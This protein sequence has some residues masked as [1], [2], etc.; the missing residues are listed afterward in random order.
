MEYNLWKSV[1][2]DWVS[3]NRILCSFA[4]CAVVHISNS[5]MNMVV[6]ANDTKLNA[7][8]FVSYLLQF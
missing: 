2:L 4:I 8:V 5:I 3:V 6:Y 1:L 7:A